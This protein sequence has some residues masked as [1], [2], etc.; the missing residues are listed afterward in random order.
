MPLS[1]QSRRVEAITVVECRGRITEGAEAAALQAHLNALLPHR[2]YLILHLG[3]VTFIDSFGIGVLVRCLARTRA[4]GDLKL[5]AVHDNVAHVLKVTRLHQV[6]ET[7]ASEAEAI[8]AFYHHARAA[9]TPDGF[10]T[11]MLCVDTSPEVL[12]YLRE[13][14][15][16][17]GY[18]VLTATNLPDALTLLQATAPKAVIIGAALRAARGTSTA[19]RFHQFANRRIVL[20]LPA[21]FA[22][23]E[24]AD[25]GRQ[26]LERIRAAIPATGGAGLPQS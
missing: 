3:D 5:C 4:H 8:A 17:A 1:L 26:L 6:F 23:R 14:L 10:D 11:D 15:H 16:Q 13:L 20:E 12:A 22:G 7:H 18:G 19:E 25:A 24:A 2:P 21:D 9:G